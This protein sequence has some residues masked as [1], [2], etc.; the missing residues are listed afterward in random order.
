MSRLFEEFSLCLFHLRHNTPMLASV[1]VPVLQKA[2][3][4][5]GVQVK[6]TEVKKA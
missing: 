6:H 3:T 4:T 1:T 2:N 5:A